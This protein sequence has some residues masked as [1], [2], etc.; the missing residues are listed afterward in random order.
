[1]AIKNMWFLAKFVCLNRL[2][3]LAFFWTFCLLAGIEF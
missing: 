1:M 2:L 3:T